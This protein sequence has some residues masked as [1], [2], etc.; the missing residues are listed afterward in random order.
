[1]AGKKIWIRVF[2]LEEDIGGMF[3]QHFSPL[4]FVEGL[5]GEDE[6][7]QKVIKA[8]QNLSSIEPVGYSEESIEMVLYKL[9]YTSGKNVLK[10]KFYTNRVLLEIFL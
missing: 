5:R 3:Y 6:G 2:K 1:M 8:L 9:C 10:N 7:I 4:M